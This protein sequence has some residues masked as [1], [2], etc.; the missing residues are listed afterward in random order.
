MQ[1]KYFLIQVKRQ[2]PLPTQPSTSLSPAPVPISPQVIIRQRPPGPPPPRMAHNNP[3][4]GSNMGIYNP[5]INQQQRAPQIV[6]VNNGSQ[7]Q[8]MNIPT[9]QMPA[10][11][12]GG[13]SVMMAPAGAAVKGPSLVRHVFPNSAIG[14]ARSQLQDQI[15]NAMEICTH[16]T[17]KVQTL[18][19]S[20]AYN[21]ARSY[22]DLKELY[23]H[24]SY[25]MTY[26]IGRFKQLQDKCIVDMREMGFKNDANSLENGQLAAGK[27]L[28]MLSR[29]LRYYLK[30]LKSRLRT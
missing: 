21:Q 24:L 19:H 23:I 28:K 27:F 9:P 5:Q 11:S 22:M 7:V 4:Y 1:I 8:A 3:A 17:G 12:N 16:L 14:M 29:Y 20:N 6:R 25:L 2:V 26:A 30:H 18:T 13:G 15:F 10:N